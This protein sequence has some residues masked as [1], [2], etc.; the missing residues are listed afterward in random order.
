M[1]REVHWPKTWS[2]LCWRRRGER[3]LCCKSHIK[4]KYGPFDH[5]SF[6]C[7]GWFRRSTLHAACPWRIDPPLSRGLA[8]TVVPSRGR[9]FWS[10]RSQQPWDVHQVGNLF[11]PQMVW[12]SW[13]LNNLS[14]EFKHFFQNGE[15][16]TMDTRE[17]KRLNVYHFIY[18]I[19]F[20]VIK[21]FAIEQNEWR[22]WGTKSSRK[23]LLR[24]ARASN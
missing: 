13:P 23:T 10:L 9:V 4:Q 11:L 17:Y 14:S 7:L 1:R 2:D 21:M 15:I 6:L 8:Q 22:S 24:K 5:I 16:C 3:I 19:S 12:K 20:I 18:F